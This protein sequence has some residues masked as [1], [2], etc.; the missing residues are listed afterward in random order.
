MIKINLLPKKPVGVKPALIQQGAIAV[1]S[2]G[3]VLLVLVIFK[4]NVKGK[5]AD[6]EQKIIST[7]GELKKLEKIEAKIEELKTNEAIVQKKIDVIKRLEKRKT[8]PV[9]ML[10]E[11]AT[12]IPEKMWLTQLKSQGPL[13]TL[14]GV[15]ID[16]ETIALFMTNLENSTQFE[17]VELKFA[18]ETK[19]ED[20]S[21]KKFS[22]T[23]TLKVMKEAEK[24]KAEEAV[25]GE[26]KKTKKK[27]KKRK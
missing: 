19:I 6:L 21:L 24:E 23:A 9:L 14:E 12:R 27:K 13:L 4:M 18:Q 26:K 2:I 22:I 20:F 17:N 3:V 25:K 7:K 5:V 8:G 11:I 16:N 15:A 10:D 1:I